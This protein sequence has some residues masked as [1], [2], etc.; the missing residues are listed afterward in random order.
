MQGGQGSG[1]FHFRLALAKQ[2]ARTHN[3]SNST[4]RPVFSTVFRSSRLSIRA[5]ALSTTLTRRFSRSGI[6]FFCLIWAVKPNDLGGIFT[7]AVLMG[8]S[9]FTM[10]P[11]ALELAAEVVWE[12][13]NPAS[14]SAVLYFLG[15]G[16]SNVILLAH[17]V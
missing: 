13:A 9:S 11:I 2:G 17:L 4:H 5:S 8:V 3:V 14:T 1:D 6:S 10:L 7:L 16:P 15:N 12:V